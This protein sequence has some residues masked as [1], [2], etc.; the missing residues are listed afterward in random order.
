MA[1]EKRDEK[2]RDEKDRQD[3]V[4]T[5]SFAAFLIWGGVILLL[6]NLGQ[7]GVLIDF[8]ERLD[9]PRARLPFD[10]PFVDVD[11]WR[12][13]FLGAGVIVLVEIL[14]RLVMPMYRRNVFGSIIW[15][16]ILFSLALGAWQIIWPVAVMVIGLAILIGGF[17][18]R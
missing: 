4:S 9:L 2:T 6:N 7:L 12:V 17:R 15:A 13:F 11:A 16:A 1:D 5:I 14:I 8:V 10:L 18:R 3:P